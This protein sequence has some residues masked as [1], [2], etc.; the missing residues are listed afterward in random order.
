MK[1]R[2][3]PY[4]LLP[5]WAIER[6]IKITPFEKYVKREGVISYG[7]SSYGYDIRVGNK[8]KLFSP[9][10]NPGM[11]VDPKKMTQKSFHNVEGD[12]VIPPN[13]YCLAEALEWIEMP[14]DVTAICVGKSTYAR[15][16]IICNL[17]PVEAQWNGRLTIE[18]SNS[19]CLPAKIYANEGICQ[20]LFFRA[21]Q[22]C[23]VSYADKKGK[24][25][26]QLGLTLAKVD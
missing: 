8:F 6:Y 14:R 10:H 26:D 5:D 13:S 15:A 19:N 17:T 7:C 3:I 2:E 16:G 1:E 25:Q 9:V 24:Y 11:V 12:C 4:G 20:L 21:E 22:E 23:D 18:I